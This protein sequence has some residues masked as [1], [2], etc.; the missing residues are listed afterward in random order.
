MLVVVVS[1][2]LNASN[3]GLYTQLVA[4]AAGYCV[5]VIVDTVIYKYNCLTCSLWSHITEHINF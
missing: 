3:S 2:R 5:D 4:E 1:G